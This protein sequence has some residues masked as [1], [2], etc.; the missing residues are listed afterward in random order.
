MKKTLL[1]L[2]VAGAAVNANAAI[3]S[4][5]PAGNNNV[6]GSEL[7]LQVYDA[8][9]QTTYVRDLGITMGDFLAVANTEGTA[10]TWAASS[11]LNDAFAGADKSQLIWGV[12]ASDTDATGTGNTGATRGGRSLITTQ[13][14]YNGTFTNP[15]VA[16]G[17]ANIGQFQQTIGQ[18]SEGTMASQANG[19]AV[20]NIPTYDLLNNLPADIGNQFPGGS[21]YGTGYGTSM[22][23]I[24]TQQVSTSATRWSVSGGNGIFTELA[25][26]WRLDQAGNLSYSVASAVPVPAAVWLLGSGLVGLVGVSRRRQEK[27]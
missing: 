6:S 26:L 11:M 16:A 3:I 9:T 24:L 2:L 8:V 23:M 13:D 21:A 1:A 27:A 10:L 25:G 4:G 5:N 17:A 7:S 19:E 12:L 15:N 18:S 22:Y 20:T 14:H